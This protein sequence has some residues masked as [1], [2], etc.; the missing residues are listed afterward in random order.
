MDENINKIAKLELNETKV[1]REEFLIKLNKYL[2]NHEYLKHFHRS[3]FCE[4]YFK[5]LI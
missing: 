2:D 5:N 4:I 1:R 3:E